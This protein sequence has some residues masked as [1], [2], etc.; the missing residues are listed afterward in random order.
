[1]LEKTLGKTRLSTR[2]ALNPATV[3]RVTVADCRRAWAAKFRAGGLDSPDLDARVLIGHALGLDHAA[4]AARA[5][6]PVSAEQQSAIAALAHRRLA[7]EP[8]A[9]ITGM[10]EFWALPLRVTDATLVPRP[11]TETVVAAA[12]RAL[13]KRGP[14]SRPW[15][16][17][18]IGTG[19]GAIAL[20][21][22]SELPSALVVGTDI[23]AA[24]LAVARDNADRL[25]IKRA[26]YLACDM[27]SALGGPFD[28]IVS[29]PPYIPTGDLDQLA[30]EV[31]LFDPRAALDG[32]GDGLQWFRALA[33][34]AVPLLS[35]NGILVVELGKDQAEPVAALIGAAGLAP[36]AP[37]PDLNGVH[38]AL[39]AENLATRYDAQ[40]CRSGLQV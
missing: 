5:D 19:T 22:L 29:N 37:Q 20:A 26:A 30:P 18:D 21:L 38:R 9:R 27:A 39:A 24:A 16:I 15:R 2:Q 14:R 7:H 36:M 28:L 1:M 8:V 17:A 33:A 11:E 12:L 40:H 4:L 3:D 32:G 10:K 35:R 34:A 23:S 6:Q 25:G 13:D 31:R